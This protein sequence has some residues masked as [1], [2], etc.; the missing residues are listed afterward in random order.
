LLLRAD[1]VGKDSIC[2]Y[3]QSKRGFLYIRR[4]SI[5]NVEAESRENKLGTKRFKIQNHFIRRFYQKIRIPKRRQMFGQI[6]IVHG[7]TRIDLTTSPLSSSTP[8]STLPHSYYPP[9]AEKS[10]ME[11]RGILFK[12]FKFHNT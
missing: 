3:S 12:C 11:H 2:A 8:L 1:I 4:I 5:A 6:F 7:K 9:S 10:R